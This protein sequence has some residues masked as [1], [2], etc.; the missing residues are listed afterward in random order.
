L[1]AETIVAIATP[2]GFGAVGIVRLSGSSVQEIALAV[3][4]RVPK[5]RQALLAWFRDKN[6]EAL[7]Q[8]LA[9][10]FPA[11][12]SFTGEDVLEFHGH[13][14]PLLLDLLLRRLLELGARPARPG[15]FSERAFLN[16]KLD[17][18]QA[19]AVADLIASGTE[20]SARLASRTLN[21]D[22]SR[23]IS[24]L[25][26]EM[27][28][29]RTYIEA[30]LDFPDEEI[31]DHAD[32][33][34]IRDIDSLLARLEAIQSSARQGYLV[35]EGIRV[36]IAGPPNVGKSSLLN[37]LTG[38]EAA[39]VTP[40]PG[41][42]R[43]LLHQEIQI[44]GLPLHITD[45][46]GL[47]HA[48]DLVERE[49]IRRA[50]DQIASADAILW[51]IDDSHGIDEQE[52]HPQ[53][54]GLPMNAHLILIRNKID[55]SGRPPGLTRLP[56]H[57]EVALSA[58]DGTGLNTLRTALKEIAGYRE[59]TEGTFLARRRHLDALHKA[60]IAIQQARA[61]LQGNGAAE[62]IAEELRLG[63]RALGEITGEFTPDDLLERIFSSFCIGK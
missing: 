28:H 1:P 50:R 19:E 33:I 14:G 26:E 60:Q 51:L 24:A 23:R 44:D 7:D 45:T 29:L 56:D 47:R 58:L 17:L 13:G 2:P 31:D 12:N 11:P 22:L 21:G 34:I 30:T 3:I 40:I 57:L 48:P 53:G 46:A 5:P 59:S 10:F 15:E 4:G 16:G 61:M 6:G 35:R 36:V 55:L 54:Q 20:T 42:T 27:I 52:P 62:F 32:G 25:V 43:D 38:S 18:A 49:G 8:G 37:A 39:I 9:L 63:H 41:T